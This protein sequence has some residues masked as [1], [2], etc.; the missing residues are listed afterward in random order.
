MFDSDGPL[1]AVHA[2][3]AIPSPR[4]DVIDPVEELLDA[5]MLLVAGLRLLAGTEVDSFRILQRRWL[6]PQ[7]APISPLLSNVYMWRF[8]LRWK[9]LGHARRF[10]AKIVNCVDDFVICGKVPADA[11]RAVGEELTRRLRLPLNATKTR[12]L[13]TPEE[14]LEFLGYRIGRNDS[15]R[16]GKAC[17]G[18]RQSRA[19]VRSTCRRQARYGPLR[20]E[21]VL[22]SL[23][24]AM[25]GWANYFQL[26]QVSPACRAV[27]A[28][29]EKRL[30]PW[31]CR[32]HKVKAG[33]TVRYPSERLWDDCGLVRLKR[34]T[35]SFP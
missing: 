35:A 29:A 8:L 20:S 23:N 10:G 3:I 33:G 4:S 14:P 28:Q 19:S 12:C 34:Q 5:A 17:I 13:R 7:G 32:K 15:P 18:T 24:R 6:V 26:R 2:G 27:D 30:R 31:L 21:Q 16:T 1:A 9:A 25:P 11:M 22:A